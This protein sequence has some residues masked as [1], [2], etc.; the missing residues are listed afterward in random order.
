MITK[1]YKIFCAGLVGCGIAAT[2]T[3]CEDFFNQESDDVL[4]SDQEHLNNAVDTI[5]SVTG[6]LAKLQALGDRTVLFGELRGDLV[7]LTEYADSNLQAIANFEVNDN[8]KYNQPS[9]YYAVI[10]NCNYFIAHADTALRSNRNEE[11]FMKEYCA[12]KAIRAWTYLQLGLVYGKVPF[13]T[14]PLLSKDAAEVAESSQKTL[15]EICYYFLHEDGLMDLPER[16][17][18]EYPEY[19]DIR[20]PSKLMY[21]PLSL[22]RG[23]LYLW[24]ATLTNNVKEYKEAA[25]QYYTYISQRNGLNSAYPI[26]RSNLD[27]WDLGEAKWESPRTGLYPVDETATANSEAI[28]MIIGD[29]LPSEGHYS[30]L[31]NLFNSTKD[32]DYRVSIKPSQR[33]KEIS[34]ATPNCVLSNDARTVFYAPKNLADYSG[35]LRLPDACP[36]NQRPEVVKG[37]SVETQKINKYPASREM[38]HIIV[39][40]RIMVYMRMAEALNRAGYPRMAYEVL[41]EGLTNQVIDTKVIPYYP[42]A[43]DFNYLVQFDFNDARYEN[44]EPEDYVTRAGFEPLATHNTI[45]IHTRGAGWTPMDTTYVLPHDTIEYNATKRAQLVKEQQAYVDS[46][47][48]AESAL[49][50]AFEGTRYYDIMRYALRQDNPEATMKKIIGARK[51]I[52][53]PT[54]VKLTGRSSWFLT[55]KGKLGY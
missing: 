13:Y 7:D 16:Y 6:I 31:R 26:G 51:G 2:L 23:D 42:T 28:T 27:M 49:E 11:I 10:N 52:D 44:C 33:V 20:V 37:V 48:L 39:Y 35:D 43:D 55:W 50:F 41:S 32:N 29:S 5:Y 22:V 3:S 19:G 15:E 47:I 4:Y 1:I 18:T 14:E 12:V 21:F 30:E 8:N 24:H 25:K 46:L 45:G 40:R 54:D 9:D 17:N 53:N 36:P 34:Q 38:T